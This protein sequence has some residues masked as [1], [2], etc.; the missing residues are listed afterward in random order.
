[1]KSKH[2]LGIVLLA[3]YLVLVGLISLL[4]LHF[5][6]LGLLQGLLALVAGILLL[7]GQ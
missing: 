1:M 3:V 6:G 7:L 4:G 2:R 5:N